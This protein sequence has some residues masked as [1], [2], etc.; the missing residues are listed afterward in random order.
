[1]ALTHDFVVNDIAVQIAEGFQFAFDRG[2]LIEFFAFLTKMLGPKENGFLGI[3]EG[4]L[5]V[6]R[7]DPF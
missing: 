3:H 5:S 1:M 6:F 2:G 7:G 4:E